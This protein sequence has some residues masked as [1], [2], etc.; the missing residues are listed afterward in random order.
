MSYVMVLAL[1][2]SQP[3]HHDQNTKRV[4]GKK[5]IQND[6]WVEN[7]P[8]L[9]CWVPWTTIEELQIRGTE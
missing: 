8:W 3:K 9:Q 7:D 4:G 1:P 6:L 2:K 5:I